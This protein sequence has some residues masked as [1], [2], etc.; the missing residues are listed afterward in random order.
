VS[1]YIIQ[2]SKDYLEARETRLQ[3]ALKEIEIELRRIQ[4]VLRRQATKDLSFPQYQD[5]D[6]LVSTPAERLP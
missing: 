3:N 6:L 5:E 2:A 1:T 4:K